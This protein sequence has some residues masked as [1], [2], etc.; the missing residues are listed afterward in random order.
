MSASQ[1]LW[2]RITDQL[3]NE[4]LTN[5]TRVYGIYLAGGMTFEQALNVV[6]IDVAKQQRRA[7]VANDVLLTQ[8]LSVSPTNI[9]WPE[10]IK[11]QTGRIEQALRT[12]IEAK[13]SSIAGLATDDPARI[14]SVSSRLARVVDNEV[15]AAS[16]NSRSWSAQ[17]V[18]ARGDIAIEGWYRELRPNACEF[19]IMVGPGPG[20]SPSDSKNYV[21]AIAH[22]MARH[23]HCHCRQVYVSVLEPGQKWLGTG[24]DIRAAASSEETQA[25]RSEYESRNYLTA[26]DFLPVPMRGI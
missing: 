6:A 4:A 15:Q 1:Q 9:Y 10:E 3:S 11:V 17:R 14:E 8:E 21:H 12:T 19:C 22:K 23:P 13:V 18:Y 5:A 25:L 24:A 26:V 2:L 16:V 20:R 7:A